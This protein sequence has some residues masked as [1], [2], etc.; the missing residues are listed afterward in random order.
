MGN[1]KRNAHTIKEIIAQTLQIRAAAPPLKVVNTL[2]DSTDIEYRSIIVR[3]E[4]VRNW[5]LYL[6]NRPY[7]GQAGFYVVM[8][9]RLDNAAGHPSSTYVLI[10]R[11]WRARA[12]NGVTRETAQSLFTP[13]GHLVIKGRAVRQAGHLLQLGQSPP[14][15]P[16]AVLQNLTVEEFSKTTGLLLQPFFIE[17]LSELD[18]GL[19]RNWPSPSLGIDKHRAYAFQW[20]ALSAT[21][22]LFFLVTRY[23]LRKNKRE[24]K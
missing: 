17:Q 10:K 21:V 23:Q 18:D 20:Y 11:G 19:I 16:G 1:G 3:G 2:L 24:K 7:Q 4:F 5:P 13:A 8:P 14:L 22:L 12:Q 15:Q 9:F 6:D